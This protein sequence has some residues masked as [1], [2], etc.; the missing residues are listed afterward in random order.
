MLFHMVHLKGQNY[1]QISH[2]DVQ[3]QDANWY[4]HIA[5][6]TYS[7]KFILFH[8]PIFNFSVHNSRHYHHV[9]STHLLKVK[10][11]QFFSKKEKKQKKSRMVALKPDALGP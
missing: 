4:I 3:D 5:I 1:A 9:K 11:T 10:W 6:G 7:M 2:I 8:R